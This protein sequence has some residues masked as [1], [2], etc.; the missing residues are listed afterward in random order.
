MD[1]YYCQEDPDEESESAYSDPSYGGINP[2]AGLTPLEKMEKYASTN[3]I[4]NRQMVPR[5]ALETLRQVVTD[6]ADVEVVFTILERLAEDV[7]C[8]IRSELMEQVPHIAIYCQEVPEYLGHAVSHHLLPLVVKFL[9]DN[10]HQVRKTSQ[11][12]LLVLLEQGLVD[13]ADVE[14]QVCPVILEFTEIT[15]EDYRIEATAL[16]SKMA[17]MIGRE[18]SE[19]LFLHRFAKLCTDP[20]FHVRK[21]CAANFGDFC[22]VV[23]P[24]A[25]EKILLPKFYALCTD[26]I[27]GVRKCCADVF[28]PVSCICSP[29]VRK[30]EL[31]PL[32]IGLL[33]DHSRWVRMAA[34]QALGPFI[35]TFADPAITALLHNENGEIIITDREQLVH[36]LSQLE[37]QRAKEAQELAAQKQKEE[38]S[39]ASSS[40]SSSN[41]SQ[42]QQSNDSALMLENKL[43]NNATATT[44]STDDENTVNNN[45][46]NMDETSD[47]SW[48]S[49]LVSG[50]DG[51][52]GCSVEERR[53]GL[54]LESDG[55]GVDRRRTDNSHYSSFLYWREPVP[56]LELV[57]VDL[58]GDDDEAEAPPQSDDET[59]TQQLSTQHLQQNLD[60]LNLQSSGDD[61]SKDLGES[62]DEAEAA[63]EASLESVEDSDETAED[64]EDSL[65]D[66]ETVSN[67]SS[68]QDQFLE[69]S[70]GSSSQDQMWTNLP[71]ITFQ[72]FDVI[73]GCQDSSTMEMYG[74]AATNDK[75]SQDNI[76]TF[77]PGIQWG[78]FSSLK[79]SRSSPGA[80]EG[81]PNKDPPIDPALPRGPPETDQNIVPQLLIDHY[82]SMIDP[83]RV[84]TVESDIAR[85]CAFSFPAVALTLGRSNWPLLKETYETLANDMQWKV[86]RTLASS[87]HEL[88]VI[89]GQEV[90]AQD[91][92]PIFNGFIKDLDEVRI[93]ILKHLSQ[94]LKLLGGQ[95]RREYLPKMAEFLKMDNERN[96]RFRLELAH[97]LGQ[98]APVFEPEDIKEHLAP[99]ALTLLQDKVAE[100]RTESTSVICEMMMCLQQ[101]LNIIP[102][103]I[104]K[105]VTSTVWT[106]RQT[107]CCLCSHLVHT[108]EYSF[109]SE[110]FLP[111][112]LE[113]THDRVPNVRL[114][115]ARVLGQSLP[116]EY[117]DD[118]NLP[119]REAILE[120]LTTLAADKDADVRDAA[121]ALNRVQPV[122][123]PIKEKEA[124]PIHLTDEETEAEGEKIGLEEQE[125]GVES[126]PPSWAQIA[127]K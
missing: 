71:V 65:P 55:G 20:V 23:G 8:L 86:R 58:A 46:V 50:K 49:N 47:E 90:A 54:Y 67:Q 5:I 91:L 105:L 31:S 70:E 83:S 53:A 124:S 13:K 72:K 126:G 33:R 45:V 7:D 127:A 121:C 69:Q 95:D 28:M 48:A 89:L 100:V 116:N 74:S 96:W 114:Q 92:V 84:Q 97:Q 62:K 110:D 106:R 10:N 4:L 93:G 118:I 9:V 56:P 104:H 61:N 17:P 39:N 12:A 115:V 34:F 79:M 102:N 113:L 98:L 77:E 52:D 38:E 80:G 78:S 64:D 30:L 32:F 85:H 117:F 63:L 88:A 66:T 122:P 26:N 59:S 37:Q 60:N 94:F 16:L 73:T 29:G 111:H 81:D 112:L 14:Q 120:C 68:N 25:T 99:I 109:F 119:D 41:S 27:W 19:R 101:D 40:S 1:I 18:M 15:S 6:A 11:A 24:E 44:T 3:N 51:G 76:C 21:V 43:N 75:Q 57:D 107:F 123:P 103:M 35:S 2:N 125:E 87:I 82:V 22:G 108:I 36:K 42:Q